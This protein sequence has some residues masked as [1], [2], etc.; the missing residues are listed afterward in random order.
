MMAGRKAFLKLLG[1]L[2]ALTVAGLAAL[3]SVGIY[4]NQRAAGEAARFCAQSPAG[5]DPALA[6]ARAEAAGVRRVPLPAGA[7]D[8]Y[9]FQGWVFNAAVCRLEVANGRVV[10]TAVRT[11]GD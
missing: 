10:A 11:E 2:A 9:Y 1:G 5:A 8:D 6:I 7:G 4:A 3:V